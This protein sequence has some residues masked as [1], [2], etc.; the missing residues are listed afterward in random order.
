MPQFD[1]KGIKVGKYNFNK[2]T[3]KVTYDTPISVGDA[4]SCTME[5]RR[6]EARLYA[7]G[8]LKEY[9][10]EITG[11][12]CS[13]GTKYIPADA[14]QLMY[15]SREK[16]RTIAEKEV[17]SLLTGS[18]DSGD[19]VGVAGYDPDMMDNIKKYYCW[20]FKKVRFGK[21]GM[22]LQTKGETIQFQTPTTTGEILPD[23]TN[24][25]DNVVEEAYVDSEEEAIAWVDAVFAAEQEESESTEQTEQTEPNP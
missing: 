6:A 25:E 18:N 15:G 24:L 9:I 21:P 23:D 8:A 2:E 1:L 20:M 14:Q 12:T 13:I 7:E 4:M 19:Y 5:I 3:K 10:S 11:G 22:S 17:T 16:V